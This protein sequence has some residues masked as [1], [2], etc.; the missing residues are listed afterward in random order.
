MGHTEGVLAAG[1]LVSEV[2]SVVPNKL[3]NLRHSK[4][5][6]LPLNSK[7]LTNHHAFNQTM[8]L[9]DISRCLAMFVLL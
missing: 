4:S 3:F 5:S 2:P 6:L 7:L 8:I 9:S 1:L